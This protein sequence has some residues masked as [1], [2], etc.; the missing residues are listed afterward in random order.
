MHKN[1]QK[2]TSPSC[3]D[4]V[5]DSSGEPA[6]RSVRGSACDQSA[7]G[8]ES[9]VAGA[10]SGEEVPLRASRRAPVATVAES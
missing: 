6:R 4:L 10:T 7:S 1:Q 2:L 8:N 9:E 5:Y 3:Y